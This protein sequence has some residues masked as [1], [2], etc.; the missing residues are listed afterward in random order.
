MSGHELF[1]AAMLT[2]AALAAGAL[3][4]PTLALLWTLMADTDGARR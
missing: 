4:L 1:A 3:A 2:L